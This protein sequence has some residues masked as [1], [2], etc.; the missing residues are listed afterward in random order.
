MLLTHNPLY[1]DAANVAI[2]QIKYHV[3]EDV[4][5]ELRRYQAGEIDVTYDIPLNQ[6]ETLK[7][8]IPE[9][10]QIAPST[11]VVYYSFNLTREPFTDINLSRALSLAIDRQTLEGRIVH[12]EAIPSYSLCGRVRFDL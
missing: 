9:Q 3:T 8:E 5:R 12:G 4:A 2:E 7:A 1:W 11:E 10:V 6:I